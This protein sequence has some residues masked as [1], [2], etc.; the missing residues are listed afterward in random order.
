MKLI[1]IKTKQKK[2]IRKVRKK[3]KKKIVAVSTL[4]CMPLRLYTLDGGDDDP[5]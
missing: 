5:F 4:Q 1:T 3:K 2:N